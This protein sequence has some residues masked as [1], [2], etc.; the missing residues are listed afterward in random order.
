MMYQN[1]ESAAQ[2]WERLVRVV[3]PAQEQPR[4]AS[5]TVASSPTPAPV[6]ALAAP[7]EPVQEIPVAAQPATPASHEGS[8]APANQDAGE[9]NE[10]VA[11]NPLIWLSFNTEQIPKQVALA[12][13]VALGKTTLAVGTTVDLVQLV[14]VDTVIIRHQ[15]QGYR[16]P[17]GATNLGD[18]AVAIRTRS[19]Q[20]ET[21]ELAQAQTVM[22]QVETALVT[23]DPSIDA[24][25][26]TTLAVKP[27]ERASGAGFLHPGL[28][29]TEADFERMRLKVKQRAE[30][31]I[32]GWNVLCSHG[33]AQ[34]G[35]N[36]RPL[37]KVIRGAIPG[38]N[39]RQMVI[40]VQRSYMLAVRWKVSGDRQCADKAVIFLNAWSSTMKELTGNADRFLAVGIQGYQWANVAEIMRTYPGW[41]PNDIARFQ[42]WMLEHFYAKSH[43]FFQRHNG[44]CIT[45]YWANWD[46]CNLADVLAVGVF[47][48]RQDIVDEALAYFYH[49]AGNGEMKRAVYYIHPG[50][51]GQWQE[52]GRD[53]GHTVFGV[54]LVGVTCEMAWNQG[55]DLY[56]YDNY[57][58]LAGAEYVAKYN[59]GYDVP[60][61]TYSWGTGQK[62]AGR[63]QEGVSGFA[64]GHGGPCYEMVYNHYVNRLGMAAPY[65]M[66]RAAKLRPEGGSG[67]DQL[68][69]GTLVH[70]R[71]PVKS[72]PPQL[73]VREHDHA[74]RLSW[75]GS[76]RA[77]GYEVFRAKESKGAPSAFVS[78]AR[79]GDHDF[80]YDDASA[81]KD[82]GTYRYQV[83]GLFRSGSPLE[84]NVAHGT[85]FPTGELFA[86]WTF[87]E[88]NGAVA[89]DAVGNR[90]PGSLS[91]KLQ[92]TGGWIGN[93]IGMDGNPGCVSLPAGVVSSLGDFT[94]AAWV[95]LRD[96]KP[97]IRIFDFGDGPGRY[98]YLTP[99]NDKGMP[100]FVTTT[101][102][103]YN[104]QTV[105]GDKP[106][107][108]GPWT[109]VAI[110]LSGKVGTLYVNGNAVGTN[111]GMDFPP[112]QFGQTSRNYL[113]R[114]QF[115]H[116]PY[117]NGWLDDVRIYRG[118]LSAKA[119]A[120][121]ASAG[122]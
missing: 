9:D 27:V 68:G 43:D 67:G 51:L 119:I 30:P 101:V 108:I 25:P 60:F 66:E 100:A 117:L 58:F 70:S 61:Q 116:D 57:R 75:W 10:S 63:S 112:F 55:I 31:W 38:Q 2:T 28:L 77:I 36:P 78:I 113:G 1:Q 98:M 44:A 87:D 48:D 122:R 85:T 12:K 20:A 32:T 114:S 53:Q 103:G 95:K 16:L 80:F 115:E 17:S 19:E 104:T 90:N 89:K 76:A 72:A 35:A 59:L 47:C 3:R 81:T 91:G 50:N 37:E 64:R 93:A 71:D 41:K 106:V 109:H 102:Y 86:H 69:Y 39:I 88:A 18:L 8:P 79:V 56:S 107:P 22:G 11:P 84:S 5:P 92:H 4:P 46:L 23:T 29:H 34:P 52:A 73:T 110:T 105:V 96:A 14:D 6:H 65:T 99:S 120:V 13:P 24:V 49:G 82:P 74:I 94:F 62:G 7:A 45:N 121:L 54:S 21:A 83:K 33:Y 26:P 15:G 42:A 118:A 97:F 40:D 111:A